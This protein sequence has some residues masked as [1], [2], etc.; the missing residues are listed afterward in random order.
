MI[1][2]A[3]VTILVPKMSKNSLFWKFF[4]HFSPENGHFGHKIY[5]KVL[6][7]E[8]LPLNFL[9]LTQYVLFGAKILL[10]CKV[11]VDSSL[12]E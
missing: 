9:N 8:N 12:I 3:K 6:K 10:K 1:F 2:S 11:F 5:A 4:G 7:L